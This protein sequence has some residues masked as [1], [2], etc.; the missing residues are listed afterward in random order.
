MTTHLKDIPVAK[1]VIL[2]SGALTA[3]GRATAV[4]FAR[5]GVQLII[6]C[7]WQDEGEVMADRLRELG[8][9]VEHFPADIRQ[10]EDVR[11]LVE[12]TVDRFGSLDV[13]I[14][15]EAAEIKIIP[16]I[17]QASEHYAETFET[18]VLGLILSL[19]HQL[20]VMKRQ[21]Q[22]CIVNLS[23]IAGH[24]GARGLSTYVASKHAVEGLTKAAALEAANF[25]VR[26]NAVAPGLNP[27]DM[28]KDVFYDD[29]EVALITANPLGMT[30]TAEE[31][32]KAIMFLASEEAR[33]I[34][35]HVLSVDGGLSAS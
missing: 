30:E 10:E 22:G 3:I 17:E 26:V 35:G 24:K 16:T 12:F 29:R 31:I 25:G 23:S 28:P 21:K 18:N 7:R 1:Q 2:L 34:T 14:N 20:L 32:A 11:G 6:S 27:A 13:A 5:P 9:D 4:A 33:F 8:A 15:A 19:K